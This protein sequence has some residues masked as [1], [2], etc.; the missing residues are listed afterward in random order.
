MA[1]QRRKFV[2]SIY[3]ASAGLLTLLGGL[4]VVVFWLFGSDGFAPGRFWIAAAA[5]L[6]GYLILAALI[7]IFT[8]S[9]LRRNILR[10]LGNTIVVASRVAE[11]DLTVSLSSA[12]AGDANSMTQAVGLMVSQLRTLVAAIRT[13]AQEAAAM[14]Q[15]ISSST[16]E[17]SASTEEVSGTCNDLTDRATKQ[18]AV[19]RAA[20]QDGDR[21][22]QIAQTLAVSAGEAADRNAA[23]ARLARD[24]RDELDASSSELQRLAEEIEKGAEEAAAL[25]AASEE[26]EKFV[27]QT[28]AI[29]RQTH[30]LALNAGIEAARAGEEGKGFA[31]VAEEVRKLAGQAAQAATQTSETVQLVQE[32]VATA[33][34]RLLRLARGG[35]AARATAHKAAEGLARVADEAHQTDEWGRQISKSSGE[36]RS[37]IEGIALRMAEVSSGT[38]D[39]AAAAQEIAASAEELSAST[40][41]VAGSAHALSE[42]A[43][44]LFGRV[45]TFKVE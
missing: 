7:I 23:L 17:M 30:M 18:A 33:R 42:T 36:V 28:K 41:Q 43:Q 11:G 1:D 2:R 40:E 4:E 27:T 13:S 12:G 37:L 24:H 19:V 10:P 5:A 38:E 44:G 31:V 22:L 32:R 15:E 20:A 21:I 34:D 25:A 3:L 35:Q 29:A 45:G 9:W 16:Q 39:V 8:V 26:I 14:A 6:G